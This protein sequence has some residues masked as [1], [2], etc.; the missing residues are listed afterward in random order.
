MIRL[1]AAGLARLVACLPGDA[2]ARLGALS[3]V[4]AWAP[5]AGL[6]SREAGRQRSPA[7]GWGPPPWLPSSL[8]R[9]LLPGLRALDLTDCCQQARALAARV[10]YLQ[11]LLSLRLSGADPQAPAALGRVARLASLVTLEVDRPQPTLRLPAALAAMPTL[12]AVVLAEVV[13]RRRLA[14]TRRDLQRARAKDLSV[15]D[16]V[17]AHQD[18]WPSNRPAGA[19][20]ARPALAAA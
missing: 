2:Q 6:A 13:L 8:E 9:S 4:V 18:G 10:S 12:R 15:V 19:P 16:L 5:L 14:L 11:Q 20:S 1:P 3:A 17:A 7:P